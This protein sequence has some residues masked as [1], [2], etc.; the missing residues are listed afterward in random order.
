[1]GGSFDILGLIMGSHRFNLNNLA[2][3]QERVVETK[4]GEVHVMH[5]DDIIVLPRHGMFSDIPPHMINH[6]ANMLA[7]SKLGVDKILS[8]TSVGSL[9]L[10]LSPKEIIMPDDYINFWNIQ[11]YF[12]DKIRHIIPGLDQELRELVHSKIRTL[13]LDIR[14]DGVYIQTHG[15]RLETRAEINMLKDHGDVVGMTMA[16]EAT[17]AKEIG[18][19][20][21]NISFIDNYCN[22]VVDRPLTIDAISKNQAKNIDNVEKILKKLVTG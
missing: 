12:D 7:F 6:K 8:I 17:L 10:E 1:M 2:D 13:P 11:T 20:Y 3:F 22:G 16:S 21:A 14:F 4:Y 5:S 15:P 18:I 19:Q 9:K